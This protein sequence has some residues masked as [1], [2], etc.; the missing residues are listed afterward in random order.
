MRV[1]VVGL[2]VGLLTQTLS[3][4]QPAISA[5]ELAGYRLTAPVLT[6]FEEASRLIADATRHDPAFAQSPLF[7]EE[8]SVSGDAPA[9]AAALES[10]LRNHPALSQALR[11]AHITSREYTRFALA[12]VAARLAH[13]FVTS[14]VLRTVPAGVAADNVAFV[15]AHHAEI[16]AI[17]KTLGI[18][19]N[20]ENPLMSDTIATCRRTAPQAPHS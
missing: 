17:L 4:G 8:I 7:T 6:Q 12:L 19:D 10:R 3:A 20:L 13:G 15:E 16:A 9:M 2:C 1:I 14:G 11:T 18:D 5:R